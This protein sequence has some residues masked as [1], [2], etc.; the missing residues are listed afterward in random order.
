MLCSTPTAEG[1]NSLETSA[2]FGQSKRTARNKK[3]KKKNFFAP[4]KLD[5]TLSSC[6]AIL[7]QYSDKATYTLP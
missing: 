1:L 2:A 4:R 3:V 6:D 5:V 7:D